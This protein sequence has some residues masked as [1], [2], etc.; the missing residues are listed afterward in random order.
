MEQGAAGTTAMS[1]GQWNAASNLTLSEASYVNV[2]V[3]ATIDMVSNELIV[4]VEA[5]YTGDSPE[6][7][8][9]I[10]VALLQNNTLGPQSGG[11]QGNNYNHMHRLVHLLTG[12]WGETISSTTTGSLFDDTY[13][14]TI[15]ADYNDIP[16]VLQDLEI[17]VFVTETQQTL[18]SGNGTYPFIF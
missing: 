11:G 15:P 3:E 10:N 16:V 9:L 18:V 4:H 17:V 1:R 14:Y 12:Q 5:Y 8:N 2:G 13:T 6:N 7:T